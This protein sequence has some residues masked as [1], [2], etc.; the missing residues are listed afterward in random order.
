MANRLTRQA[1]I[2]SKAESTYGTDST[3]AAADDS[4]LVSSFTVDPLNAQNVNRDLIRSFLGGSEQLVGD[5]HIAAQYA[6]EAVGSG[7]VGTAPVY[8]EQ[9]TACGLAVTETTDERVDVTPVSSGFGSV[10]S[11]YHDS[12][13]KHLSTGTRGTFELM[14]E[15]GARPM[16]NFSMLGIH[17]AET[18][19]SNPTGVYTAFQTPQAITNANTAD[20]VLGCTHSTSGAPALSSGTTYPSKGLKV[21][22]GN[23]VNHVA[24]LGGESVE[25]SQREVTGSITLDL[26]SAQEVTLM[27][28]V[29]AA[30]L[31]SIG[32]VH[33]T[34]AGRALLVFMPYCQLINPRKDEL[35]GKRLITF[36]FRAVPSLGDDELRLVFF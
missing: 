26:T 17:N 29:R 12:G 24:L 31:T 19:T 25:I 27:A 16:F 21:N 18:A 36:D 28:A 9:L 32:F 34:V 15:L 3:P 11:Y 1:V 23:V 35:N 6:I 33:G 13:T 8:A 2:L 30:T 14:M 7:T 20:I 4:L 10:T 5:R 22:L